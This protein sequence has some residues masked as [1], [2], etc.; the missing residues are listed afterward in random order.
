MWSYPNLVPLPAREVERI[1]AAL[2]AWPFERILGAWWG[3]LVPAEGSEVVRRSAARYVAAL[4]ARGQVASLL[5][6]A[7]HARALPERGVGERVQRLVQAAQLARQQLEALAELGLAVQ[8][9]E[10][11]GD[12]VEPLE[13]GLELAVGH[14]LRVHALQSNGRQRA[15]RRQRRTPTATPAESITTSSGEPTRPGTK[16]WWISSVTA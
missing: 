11:V 7:A 8:P 13:H 10:L 5:L 3:T 2:E 6:G 4:A 1:A 15:N 12:P 14:L 16:C 9:G